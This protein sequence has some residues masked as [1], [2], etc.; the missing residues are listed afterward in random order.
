[1]TK[2]KAHLTSKY[3]SGKTK[4][5]PD[6]L[7][8]LAIKT[9]LERDGIPYEHIIDKHHVGDPQIRFEETT[10]TGIKEV[11]DNLF[12]LKDYFYPNLR[13]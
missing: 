2:T 5:D 1:M 10:Y 13:S 8:F 9:L 6:Y 7:D 12:W 3:F 4:E 11:R